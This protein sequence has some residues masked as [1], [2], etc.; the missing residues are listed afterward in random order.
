L[1]LQRIRERNGVKKDGGIRG[2]NRGDEFE[3]ASN[4]KVSQSVF[5]YELDQQHQWLHAIHVQLGFTRCFAPS[6]P[7]NAHS[8]I[9]AT[10]T[11]D[12]RM[13]RQQQHY[14]CLGHATIQLLCDHESSE[15]NKGSWS[16]NSC[17]R[18]MA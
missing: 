11:S 15:R 10:K 17:S 18:G 3:S 1:R 7:A 13:M 6:L 14:S 4:A 9:G 8:D 5:I 16:D 12:L 2:K